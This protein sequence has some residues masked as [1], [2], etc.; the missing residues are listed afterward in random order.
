MTG[1]LPSLTF[2]FQTEHYVSSLPASSPIVIGSTTIGGYGDQSF[3]SYPTLGLT[4]NLYNGGRDKAGYQGAEAGVRAAEGDV[5]HQAAASL[6]AALNAYGD[7]LK[8]QA[9]ERQQAQTIEILQQILTRNTQRYAQG[10]VDLVSVNQAR[11]NLAQSE[12][13]FFGTCKTRAEKSDALAQAVGLRLGRML[14]LQ[15]TSSMPPVREATL[16]D[17]KLEEIVE[18]DPAVRAARERVEAASRKL[19]Q[20]RGAYQPTVALTGRYDWVGQSSDGFRDAYHRTDKNSYRVGLVLQQP[21]GPFTTEYA[22]VESARADLEKARIAYQAALI[23]ADTRVRS[24]LNGKRQTGQVVGAARRSAEHAA[25]IL[26]LTEQNFAQGRTNLDIVGQARI[27]LQ[28]ELEALEER[29][30]EDEL[31]G[32]QLQ[33]SFHPQAF[34]RQLMA[35]VGRP[36][37]SELSGQPI[38]TA[39]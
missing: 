29:K 9:A 21:L 19:D 8:A 27:A 12:R 22:A 39:P 26:Q 24:S 7:L 23:E 33:R 17:A 4:W 2:A 30:L 1:F 38:A 3:T 31:Q 5:G 18:D 6:V 34:V 13:E 32:W 15:A 37:P 35:A 36:L 11:M 28:K 20:A 25:E 16:D 10:R 14:L